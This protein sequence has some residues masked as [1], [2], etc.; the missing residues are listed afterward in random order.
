MEGGFI[1]KRI[2]GTFDF[3]TEWRGEPSPEVDAAWSRITDSKRYSLS[4]SD[5]HSLRNSRGIQP[6]RN[7]LHRRRSNFQGKR[8]E[9]RRP[10]GRRLHGES[11]GLP[12]LALP[13]TLRF[14]LPRRSRSSKTYPFRISSASIPTPITTAPAQSPGKTPPSF[15]AAMSVSSANLSLKSTLK[16]QSI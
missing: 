16:E 4:L 2:N 1:T 5:N 9:A 13:G 12:S 8:C 3:Q 7:G 6:F 11:G 14:P 15:S 10:H